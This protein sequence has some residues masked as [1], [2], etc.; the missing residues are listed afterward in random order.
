MDLTFN[1]GIIVSDGKNKVILDPDTTKIPL[2]WRSII[3]HAHSDHTAGLPSSSY[4]YTTPT[5]LGIYKIAQPKRKAKNVTTVEFNKPF[6][7]GELEIEFFPAGHLLGAT[8]VVV[9][10][11]N[12]VLLYTGDF[13]SVDLLCTNKA[14]FPDEEIPFSC[15]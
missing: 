3:T 2:S 14:V 10:H 7:V 8:Q 1:K 12:T 9:R 11:D 5:T 15:S 6:T 13:C 4:S